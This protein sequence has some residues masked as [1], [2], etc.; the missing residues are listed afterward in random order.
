MQRCY[1][2]IG[3]K[4]EDLRLGRAVTTVFDEESDGYSGEI[5]V[6]TILHSKRA[7]REI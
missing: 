3:N 1:E 7:K 5:I 2:Q 6:R 4:L